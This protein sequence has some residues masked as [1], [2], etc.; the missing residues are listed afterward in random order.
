MRTRLVAA[1]L[2]S[3][4]CLLPL[5][6]CSFAF[7]QVTIAPRRP[8]GPSLDAKLPTAT[9]RIDSNLVL[10]PVSVCDPMN[11]PVTGLEKEHFK[12]F[13]DKV[14]QTVTHFSMEDVPLSI[15]LV[16]DTS[17]SMGTKL[18]RSRVAA[19]EFFKWANPEDDFFLVEF[20]E[21]PKLVVPFTQ[22][23]QEIQSRLAFAPSKG[24]TALLDAILLA[25]H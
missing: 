9:L 23:S 25:M 17:G 18:R 16:F 12:V 15:G 13:E 7:A 1:W 24:R 22:D 11:R 5:L 4:T 10:V 2:F 6:V 20:N 19:A 3:L 21:Q 8:A 14:E